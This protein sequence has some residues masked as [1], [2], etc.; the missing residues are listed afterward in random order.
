MQVLFVEPPKEFWF[1]P[2]GYVPPPLGI[3]TL[4]SSLETEEENIDI[5]V[6]D[7]QSERLDWDGL[8]KRMAAFRPDIVAPSGLSSS[9]AYTV[10]ARFMM[11]LFLCE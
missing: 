6:L 4:A 11:R 9:N 10:S 2:G 8:E 3:L 7:C 1:I 5:E